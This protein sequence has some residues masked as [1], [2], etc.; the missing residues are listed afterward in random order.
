MY[1]GGW[2]EVVEGR[3]AGADHYAASA[4]S[5]KLLLARRTCSHTCTAPVPDKIKAMEGDG[6]A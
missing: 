2:H 1:T 6:G 4:D 3:G 5:C